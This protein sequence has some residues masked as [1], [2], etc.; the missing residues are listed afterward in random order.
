MSDQEL[1][2]PDPE[3][4]NPGGRPKH[5]PTDFT[6]KQVESM[7]AVGIIKPQIALVLGIN[8]STLYK[9]YREILDTSGIKANSQ[10]AGMLFKK[11][12]EGDTASI[13]FWCKTRMGMKEISVEQKQ[14][15][16][17]DGKPINPFDRDKTITATTEKFLEFTKRA[18]SEY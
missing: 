17:E 16:D 7:A 6:R 1:L 14:V 4:K 18:E 10:V 15:L 3:N 2:P 8:E 11:C 13:I 12:M 9:H 5:E